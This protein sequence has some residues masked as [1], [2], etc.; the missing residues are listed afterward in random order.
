[1]DNE[2]FYLYEYDTNGYH[3]GYIE[4]SGP[5][6]V[7]AFRTIIKKA[8]DEKRKVIITDVGDMCV[9]HMEDGKV[10]FPKVNESN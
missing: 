1:M 3:N 9:F 10:I 2:I 8:L 4:V 5:T 6:L 7:Q